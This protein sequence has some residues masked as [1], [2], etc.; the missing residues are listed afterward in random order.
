MI[1]GNF[2]MI[3]SAER[4]NSDYVVLPWA[5]VSHELLVGFFRFP[6]YFYFEGA[7]ALQVFFELFHFCPFVKYHTAIA[8]PYL[9]VKRGTKGKETKKAHQHRYRVGGL[10]C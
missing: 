1:N 10:G 9:W 3:Q 4:Q 2:L 7:D 8:T 6:Y 5:A